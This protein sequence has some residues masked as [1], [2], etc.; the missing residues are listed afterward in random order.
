MNGLERQ[1]EDLAH[2]ASGDKYCV[3]LLV[4]RHLKLKHL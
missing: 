3:V 2:S 4:A 1:L